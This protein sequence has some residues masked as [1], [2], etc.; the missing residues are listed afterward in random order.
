[1]GNRKLALVVAI[2]LGALLAGCSG[3]KSGA[4]PEILFFHRDGGDHYARM[5]D[6]LNSLLTSAP[7]LNAAC[8]EI[9]A[10]KALLRELEERYGLR[11]ETDEAPEIFG[12]RTV[13]VGSTLRQELALREALVLCAAGDCPSPLK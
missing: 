13:I 12:G 6:V 9:E 10:N 2:S 7:G 5:K 8:N 1:M 4:D 3:A 11:T